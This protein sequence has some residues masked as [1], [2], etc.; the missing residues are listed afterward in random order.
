MRTWRAPTPP[1]RAPNGTRLVLPL[2]LEL[3]AGVLLPSII[4]EIYF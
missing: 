4:A 1:F 3:E 2:P